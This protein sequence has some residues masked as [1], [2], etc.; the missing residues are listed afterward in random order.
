MH[1]SHTPDTALP[2]APDPLLRR[3]CNPLQLLLQHMQR[4]TVSPHGR[5]T[6]ASKPRRKLPLV[7]VS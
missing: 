7:A 6:I 5:S 3:T 1:P 4:L 2:R